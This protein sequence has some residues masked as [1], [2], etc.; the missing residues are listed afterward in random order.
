MP[1]AK[2]ERRSIGMAH[3][4][5]AVWKVTALETRLEQLLEWWTHLYE[6]T[7]PDGELTA[8][9]ESQIT[10]ELLAE[11]LDV[12]P[13]PRLVSPLVHDAKTKLF[14]LFGGDH[15]DYLMN[16]TWTFD[17]AKRQWTHRNPEVRP[18]RRV[19]ITR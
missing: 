17:P 8:S 11:L 3:T 15:G 4:A 19:A 14:V 10:T 18:P 13:A 5:A 7:S 9:F 2:T 1:F 12:E 6:R 16:D